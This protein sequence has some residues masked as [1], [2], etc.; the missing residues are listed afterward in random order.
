LQP[1]FQKIRQAAKE[2]YRQLSKQ[3]SHLASDNLERILPAALH[4]QVEL[5]F[6]AVGT[7]Q[8]GKFEPVSLQ[9]DQNQVYRP[10]DEDLLDRAAALTLLNGG[11]VFALR[12]DQVPS[13]KP[14]AAILRY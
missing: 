9:I 7:Q 3:G 10:G 13:P 5:L 12:N 1:H 8:W 6:V 14:A 11:R 4:G 2:R